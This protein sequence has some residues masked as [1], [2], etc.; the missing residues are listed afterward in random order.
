MR[1]ADLP[2]LDPPPVMRRVLP[3]EL[4]TQAGSTGAQCLWMDGYTSCIVTPLDLM[5]RQTVVGNF[6]LDAGKPVRV[7]LTVVDRAP[8]PMSR[9]NVYATRWRVHDPQQRLRLL[10]LLHELN[11]GADIPMPTPAPEL[12]RLEHRFMHAP[13][14]GGGSLYLSVASSEELFRLVRMDGA[15]LRLTFPRIP[16]IEQGHRLKLALQLHDGIVVD[17][18]PTV[19]EV[20]ETLLHMVDERPSSSARAI[21][22]RVFQPERDPPSL[23]TIH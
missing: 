4:R 8:K 15:R 2:S 9:G 11:P 21:L 14:P 22:M 18:N 19:T 17:L 10:G 23:I 12:P 5:D 1:P 16:G 13:A 6:G 7:L 3:V 20:T